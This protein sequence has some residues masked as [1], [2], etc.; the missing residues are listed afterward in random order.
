LAKPFLNYFKFADQ[1]Y[2]TRP[3]YYL[4]ISKTVQK[5]IKKYYHCPSDVIHPPLDYK[6]WSK[7]IRNNSLGDDVNSG[8]YYL[9]ASRLASYKKTDLVIKAF[10][11]NGLNLLVVGIGSQE[12]YLKKIAKTNIKFLGL[13]SDQ[14]L[15]HLYA[16]AKALIFPQ[17][18]DFGLVPLEAQAAGTPVI[19]YNKGGAKE[20]IVNN[21]TGIFFNKSTIAS[22]NCAINKFES[23]NH[24]ITPSKC[25]QKARKFDSAFFYKDFSAKVISLWQ[26]HRRIYML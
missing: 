16:N 19:A 20:T 23:K 11:Q 17:L 21:Q 8:F 12:R 25:R 7:T 9:L 10:N 4:A 14:K 5:R 24:Q 18:E 13:V 6:F 2:S 22:L 3:D 26:K 1:I 15:R